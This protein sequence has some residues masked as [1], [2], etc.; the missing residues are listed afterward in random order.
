MT[1]AEKIVRKKLFELQDPEYKAFHAKLMPT[2]DESKIIGVRVP[3]LRK[4]SSELWKD[5]TGME[6][7]KNLSHTYYE[8]NNIHAFCIEKIKDF[9]TALNETDKFLP[10]IDNWATCDMFSP[11]IFAKHT[12]IVYEKCLSWIAT[13]KTY[14]VRYGVGM[15]MRYFLDE[16]FNDKVLSIVSG[17]KS[18]E[19]Y[20]NM[21]ISWFF[22]TALAKQ[23]DASLKCMEDKKLDTWVHNKA[24]QKAIESNRISPEK[25]EYLKKLRN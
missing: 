21:M 6:F 7:I 3:N 16:R 15:L 12:D 8:E 19:Y 14:T 11:K 13:G 22:A 24:I 23:Y 10:Y 4:L 9:D 18:D 1:D 25:K 20:V 17:I 5:G 2:V